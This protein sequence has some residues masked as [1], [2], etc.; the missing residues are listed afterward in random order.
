MTESAQGSFTSIYNITFPWCTGA[1]YGERFYALFSISHLRG[2]AEHAG[3]YRAAIADIVDISARGFAFLMSGA[4]FGFFIDYEISI[5]LVIINTV[6]L[7]PLA[8]AFLYYSQKEK[9]F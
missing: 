8:C 7:Q 3:G 5:H 2:S 9:A 6:V 1:L 4:I